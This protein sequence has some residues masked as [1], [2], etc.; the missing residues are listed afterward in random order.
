MPSLTLRPAVLRAADALLAAEGAPAV[1]AA[2]AAL[3]AACVHAYGRQVWRC[4]VLLAPDES[5][6]PRPPTEERHVVWTH[7]ATQLRAPL[8]AA[9]LAS[10]TDGHA[11]L[12]L[13][14]L[15]AQSLPLNELY[16]IL[17]DGGGLADTLAYGARAA[18]ALA[19]SG[20]RPALS[21]EETP[22]LA[23]V[24]QTLR[25]LARA[26]P[27]ARV[28]M[29]QRRSPDWPAVLGAA[30]RWFRA[31]VAEAIDEQWRSRAARCVDDHAVVADHDGRGA[32][33]AVR[34]PRQRGRVHHRTGGGAGAAPLRGGTPR[35]VR[36]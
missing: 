4:G 1:E 23:D 13:S 29:E 22:S 25:V 33:R 6:R 14:L 35:R 12:A 15:I 16:A 36:H 2:A 19:R 28:A 7:L 26:L 8:F 9:L 24:Q 18:V 27:H 11:V 3:D 21:H 5:G 31:C 17:L 34:V 20:V 30:C 32:G 10:R